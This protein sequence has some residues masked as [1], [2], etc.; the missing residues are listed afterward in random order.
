MRLRSAG[1][2]HC[3]PSM[4]ALQRVR[5]H[6]STSTA[7][8]TSADGY[9]LLG[10]TAAATT[11]DR[12]AEAVGR[13]PRPHRARRLIWAARPCHGEDTE[14]GDL[15]RELHARR[16]RGSVCGRAERGESPTEA[17]T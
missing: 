1:D 10:M 17:R 11:S 14:Y 3:R 6:T 8:A 9:S 12:A 5:V 16:L 7:G 15:E 2:N 4:M 13:Q